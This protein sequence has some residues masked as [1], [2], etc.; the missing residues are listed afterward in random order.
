MLFAGWA[1]IFGWSA[2]FV[3]VMSSVY[4]GF[5][6]TFL[7]GIIGALW[8]FIDGATSGVIIA[9]IYNAVTKKK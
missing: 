3:A 5:K 1:A 4:I 7:G 9:V 8:G 6:P 2:K